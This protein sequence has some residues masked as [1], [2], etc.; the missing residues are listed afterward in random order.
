MNEERFR[1]AEKALWSYA[2]ASPRERRV[3][4]AVS[5]VDVRVQEVGEGRP[6]LFVHGGPN[7]GSTWAVLAA[8]L[9]GHRCLVLDRPGTGLSEP[10][11]LGL[12]QVAPFA[13]RLV[14]EVLDALGIERADFIGS[15][16]GSYVG[17]R[18]A[19]AHPDR[20][21][22]MV[23]LG[24]P[25][26]LDG[27]GVP[28]FMRFGMLPG[29]RH[30]ITALPPT[31]G[32][33]RMVMRQI[34]HGRSLDAGRFS[35]PFLTWYLALQR[36]TDTMRNELAL[37]ATVGS[38]ARGFHPSLMLGE[39]VLG[40]AAAPAYLLWGEV[41]PFGGPEVG[42]RL[43]AALPSAELEVFPDAGHLPWLDD[44]DRSAERI[45]A[46][47]G[48]ARGAATGTPDHEWDAGGTD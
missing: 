26:F 11:R 28:P 33:V 9:T 17:L 46:F 36:Y 8:R 44:P 30:L 13:D 16:F 45:G 7:S 34:G 6:V 19:A 39:D 37:I 10:V 35:E 42:R 27:G 15:S 2:G 5:G 23:H 25:P 48:A 29:A 24:C 47:L 3:R 22:R 41:D 40:A 1:E 14:V 43:A 12:D 32:A 31:M 38:V 18:S 21:G 20:I 4:L